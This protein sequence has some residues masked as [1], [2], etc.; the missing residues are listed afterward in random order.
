[1]GP[2]VQ[3]RNNCGKFGV[4]ASFTLAY[5][6]YSIYNAAK[7]SINFNFH[8]PH[9]Y[10]CTEDKT[11]DENDA[12]VSTVGLMDRITKILRLSEPLNF[13]TLKSSAIIV[14]WNDPLD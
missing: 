13:K 1:M 14:Y 7:T 3:N 10:F 8:A 12:I 9:F 11:L 4:G 2:A 6:T 5:A